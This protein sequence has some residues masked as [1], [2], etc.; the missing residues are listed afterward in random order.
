MKTVKIFDKLVEKVKPIL[1]Y[2]EFGFFVYH[3]NYLPKKVS[4]IVFQTY[5]EI[6]RLNSLIYKKTK[7]IS[8]LDLD[9]ESNLEVKKTL[10]DEIKK[11]ENQ[12]TEEIITYIETVSK[13]TP[14]SLEKIVSDSLSEKEELEDYPVETL[15]YEIFKEINIT[16]REYNLKEAGITENDIITKDDSASDEKNEV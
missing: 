2:E 10:S 16:I 9:V 11:L 14:G 5:D 15:L 1:S 12:V 7:N 6:N 3:P 8:D 13:L 4:L